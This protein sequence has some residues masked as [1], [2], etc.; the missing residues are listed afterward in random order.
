MPWAETITSAGLDRDFVA[1]PAIIEIEQLQG[2]RL[3][4]LAG[5]GVVTAGDQDYLAVVGRRT[6]LM[7]EDARIDR[8][9]LDDLVAGCRIRIDAIHAERTGIVERHQDVLRRYIGRHVD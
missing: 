1:Q 9:T 5:F 4:G 6:H 7:G 3:L 2:A 8:A